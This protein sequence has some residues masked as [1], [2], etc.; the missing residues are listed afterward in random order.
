MKGYEQLTGKAAQGFP[1]SVQL[2]VSATD[3]EGASDRRTSLLLLLGP[4]KEIEEIIATETAAWSQQAANQTSAAGKGSVDAQL[5]QQ[6]AQAFQANNRLQQRLDRLDESV[7]SL[8]TDLDNFQS[9]SATHQRSR[10]RQPRRKTRLSQMKARNPSRSEI[11]DGSI[12]PRPVYPHWAVPH[13][14]RRNA[15]HPSPKFSPLA[16]RSHI[17]T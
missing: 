3:E 6:L 9:A 1:V 13:C 12:R 8:A 7:R 14:Y 4:V 16:S 17:L 2:P 5:V 10:S 15:H 11:Y